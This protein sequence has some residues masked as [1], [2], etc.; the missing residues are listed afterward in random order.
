MH[1]GI[2]NNI[3]KKILNIFPLIPDSNQFYLTG[4]TALA[5]FFLS[6]RKSND[7]DFFTSENEIVLPFSK[8]LEEVLKENGFEVI[9]NKSFVSFIE[10]LVNKET[11]KTIIHL[12]V[13]SNFRLD[14]LIVCTD[15]NNI[16]IDSFMDIS[17]NKLLALFGRAVLR[18]FIDV[19]FIINTRFSKQEMIDMAVQKDPG[20]DLYWLCVSFERIKEFPDN[21]PDMLLLE[22]KININELKQFYTDWIKEISKKIVAK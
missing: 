6:H 11:E 13:D 16:Q 12:A 3:Q 21:S 2:I 19:Y 10:L 17:A 1:L 7:L 14:K 4:G 18:D 5:G 8:K 22:K 20:F 15:Y 9:R